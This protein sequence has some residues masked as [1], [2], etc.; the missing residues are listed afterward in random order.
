MCEKFG[1]SGRGAGVVSRVGM[2]VSSAVVAGVDVGNGMGVRGT[3]T[4][5]GDAGVGWQAAAKNETMV[6][7]HSRRKVVFMSESF[8]LIIYYPRHDILIAWIKINALK[9]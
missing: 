2:E 4:G 3:S 5:E 9:M 8:P 1:T 6:I 7:I